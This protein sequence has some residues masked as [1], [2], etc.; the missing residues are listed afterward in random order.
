MPDKTR[1]EALV[2]RI[3]FVAKL[4]EEAL[5]ELETCVRISGRQWKAAA[6]Q[7]KGCRSSARNAFEAA[8]QASRTIVEETVPL[9]AAARKSR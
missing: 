8:E 9:E 3:D 1:P 7:L 4:L 5:E 6:S 2:V